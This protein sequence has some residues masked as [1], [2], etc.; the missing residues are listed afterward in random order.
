METVSF[1]KYI[2]SSNIINFI[3]MAAILVWI[4]VKFNMGEILPKAIETV[5]DKIQKSDAEKSRAQKILD[6]AKALIDRL[7]Q[8]VETLEKNS[9][10]KIEV[11]KED[12]ENNAQKTIEGLQQSIDR[13]LA[14]EEKKISNVLTDKTSIASVELA[15]QHIINVLNSNPDLH[16]QF[17]QNSL[18]ELDRVKL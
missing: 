4:F 2:L 11:F 6:E 7:P 9:A 5:K 12:L 16:N 14:I 1:V 3:L 18:D 17:I 15:K 10:Q 8:D 13:A